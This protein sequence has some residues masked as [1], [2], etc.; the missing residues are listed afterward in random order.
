VS[1]MRFFSLAETGVRRLR[2][3]AQ[4]AEDEVLGT[5]RARDATAKQRRSYED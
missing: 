4:R 1:A 3:M 2:A 5:I